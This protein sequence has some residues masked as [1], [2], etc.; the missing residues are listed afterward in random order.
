MVG[1]LIHRMFHSTHKGAQLAAASGVGLTMFKTY[2]YH[3]KR[4]TIHPKSLANSLTFVE[5]QSLGDASRR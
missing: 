2:G 5:S 3:A 4:A 1:F